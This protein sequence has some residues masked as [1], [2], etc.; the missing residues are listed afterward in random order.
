MFIDDK[1]WIAQGE[2]PVYL[3]P[4]MAN[5]HGLIAGATGTG[6]TT[7]LKAMAESFSAMGVPV[8][9]ADIKGDLASLAVPGS[10]N[11][12]TLERL[13]LLGIDK[14]NYQS[15]PVRFWDLF[16]EGGHPVRTTVSEMGPLLLARLLGLSGAQEGVLNIVFRIADDRGMLLLDLKD[17]RAMVRYVGD[18]AKE[19]TFDYGNIAPQSAGAI[20]RSLLQLEDQGGEYFFGE[21]AL[22]IFDWMKTD[23]DGRGFINVLHCVRLFQMPVLYSTFLLWMLAELFEALPEAGDTDKPKLVFFFDEAHLLF[24]EAPKALLDKV[25]QVVR[26]VRSKGIGVYFITQNPADLPSDVLGQLGNRVQHA[27]RGF[28]PVEQRQI[29]AAAETF[30]PNPKLDTE[31]VLT[32]LATGEALVSCLDADGRPGIVERGYIVTPQSLFGT[33]D[34]SLRAQMITQS[35]MSGKYE[36]E[37][38]RESA[39]EILTAKVKQEMAAQQAQEAAEQQ[40]KELELRRKEYERQQKEQAR[41]QRERDAAARRAYGTST[42]RSRS[43][44]EQMGNTALNTIGRELGRSVARGLFGSLK[45]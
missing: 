12:R 25:E 7:T 35:P 5:R 9:L 1:I 26:L 34:D 14:H 40:Q 8:F 31:S 21:P 24:D 6:K 2:Q 15:F 39:Y 43:P 23:T 13:K 16:G 42:R 4:K 33:I 27:L 10:D 36:R 19:F 41:L 45:W 18:H 3:L 32:E 30:R 44:L 29:R 38:D 22:D 17:L 11:P 20:Q 28:T 37:I